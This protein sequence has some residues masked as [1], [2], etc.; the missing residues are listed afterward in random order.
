VNGDSIGDLIGECESNGS[1]RGF[2]GDARELL[3][4]FCRNTGVA[5]R[6]A[7]AHPT[8]SQSSF[9]LHA[10]FVIQLAQLGVSSW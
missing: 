9:H 5:P 8:L 4:G 3:V 2:K 1:M 7:S 6:E 10:T